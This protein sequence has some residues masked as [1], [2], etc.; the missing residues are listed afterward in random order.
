M[1]VELGQSGQAG[2]E[3]VSCG[4]LRSQDD[5]RQVQLNGWVHRRRD[6]GALIFI[7]LR[8]RDGITQVVLNREQ[9][10]Q[11][12]KLAE[13]VRSEYV[14]RVEG[15]VQLRG[16][17]RVNPNLG[18]GEVEVVA[19]QVTILNEAKP[20][21]FEI[22]SGADADE[23]LR[24][25]YRYLDL[26]RPRMQRNL[27]LRHRVV[28]F[29]RDYLDERGFVEIETPML[30]NETPEGA[31]SYLVPSRIHPGEFYALPQSPQ[32]LKQLLM[33]S[34][35]MRYFQIA[36]CLRDEDLR[37]DR[38]PEF[39]QLDLEMSFVQRDDVL[40][41]MEGLFAEL[42]ERVSEK[43][44]LF[45]PFPRLTFEESM[46]RFGNDKPDMR[47]G[48]ELTSLED[49]LR[50]GSFAVFTSAIESGGS[51][52]GIRV[53]GAGS[54]TRRELDEL[55]ETAKRYGAKGLVWFAVEEKAEGGVQFRGPAAKF[56]TED[57][58]GGIVAAFGAEVGDLLLI[59]AGDTRSTQDVLGRLRLDMGR[60][61]DLI[62]ESV[63][64]YAWIIDPPLFEWN[65]EEERW[66]STHH[67]FT[68]PLPEDAHLLETDPGQV[69][70]AAYDIVCNGYELASGSIRIHERGLQFR[71][72][73]LM[74]YAAEDIEVRF[75]HLLAAFE[76]G[77]PP[78]GGIAPGID[79]LVMLL[80]SEANIREVIAFPKTAQA[81]DLMM[82]A[83][84]PVSAR[85]LKELH[86]RVVGEQ[87]QGN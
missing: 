25:K 70:A 87:P 24:L 80:A 15:T 9:N 17:E 34:G 26:R 40:D 57:E 38:Q 53:P 8:D 6:Q 11:A 64:A 49:V 27:I 32:Q 22:A 48:M 82:G 63:M 13:S 35:M 83:P 1:Q 45:K 21:P 36:R 67:P 72:F 19:G 42:T 4:Q 56:L 79:R 39:T 75:G 58:T 28:K 59:V 81:R 20:L 47:F 66:D 23:M 14:L 2:Y 62:D 10:S 43:K 85:A 16:A 37:A 44:V 5:G 71:I 65:A 31:R 74:G 73:E 29:I 50:A 77:A 54:Y 33:V 51:V 52:A 55:T 18:T 78:H 12:H 30:T 84:S 61:L 60:K 76:Y 46:R 86:I 68:S 41:L 7:D 69:R 3:R